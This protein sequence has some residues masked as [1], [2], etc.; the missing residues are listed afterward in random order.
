MKTKK[1][2]ANM[3]VEDV[4]QTR[5]FYLELGFKPNGPQTSEKLASFLVGEDEFVMHFFRK[6]R[7]ELG[8]ETKAADISEGSEVM[9]TLSADSKQEV[10]DWA[11]AVRKANGTIVFDPEKDENKMFE[12]NDYYVL[13]FADPDGHKFNVFFNGNK[14]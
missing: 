6:D 1:I 14:K 7:F 12:E 13:V 4:E 2:W 10:N 3:A 9:F 5:K 11:E 8:T